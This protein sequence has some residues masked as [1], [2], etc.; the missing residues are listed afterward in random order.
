MGAPWSCLWP[1]GRITRGNRAMG[2]F[3]TIWGFLFRLFPC[4]A[5]RGLRRVGRPGKDSPVLVTCNFDLTIKRLTRVLK[6]AGIDAWLLAAESKG[7]NVWCAAGAGEFNTGSVVSAVKTSGLDSLLDHRILILPPLAA[8]GV[9]ASAVRDQTGWRTRWGPVRAR[10][11]PLY[12]T[13]GFIRDETMKRAEYGWRERLD[14]SL[15]SFFI[16]YLLGAVGFLAADPSLFWDY[17]LIAVGIWLI[18][19][20]SCP[21]I[22][23]KNGLQK[24][25]FLTLP[26]TAIAII[27]ELILENPVH[28][29]TDLL[30]A[31]ISLVFS[32]TELGG[33]SSTMSS[34]FD[35]FLARLGIKAVGNTRFAGTI[36]T[37]LLNGQRRLVQDRLLCTGCRSCVEVCPQGV[38]IMDQ[39]HK[40]IPDRLKACTACR[41]CLTQCPTQA[42]KAVKNSSPAQSIPGS[43]S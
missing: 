37:D 35:P 2:I 5:P 38:W 31:L 18:F 20:L 27:L 22:P 6:K 39:D 36:R 7:V 19:Y 43:Q 34:D 42:I 13:N 29:R 1:G 8:P 24:I 28:M 32:G 30:I 4:P 21:Y 11:L 40:A 15:G 16:F 41:A 23:G 10:D 9:K 3:K 26:L 17:T 33:V 25:L 14:T 12:L